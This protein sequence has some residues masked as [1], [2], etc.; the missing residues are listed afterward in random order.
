L[1]PFAFAAPEPVTVV[2]RYREAGHV[3]AGDVTLPADIRPGDLV[4][5]SSTGAFRKETTSD[6][7][8]RHVGL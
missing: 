6:L 4:A 5:V 7:L 1:N 2:G 8:I 3:L